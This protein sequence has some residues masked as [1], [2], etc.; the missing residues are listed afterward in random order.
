V[1]IKPVIS[2]LHQKNGS[3][4]IQLVLLFTEK[5]NEQ[6]HVWCVVL[7]ESLRLNTGDSFVTPLSCGSVVLLYSVGVLQS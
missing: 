7:V 4:H 1:E 5:L 2:K 6:C 3:G